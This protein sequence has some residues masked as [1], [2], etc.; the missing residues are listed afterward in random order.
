MPHLI[1]EYSDNI[2]SKIDFDKLLKSAVDT[3]VETGV[4]PLGGIRARA[5][6]MKH[7]HISTG[8][9]KFGYIHFTLKIGAG[10][11][12]EEKKTACDKIWQTITDELK[13]LYDNNIVAISLEV[14]ELHPTLN[15]KKN[16]IHEYLKNN[17]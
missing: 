8:D 12:D 9:E 16:K 1:A 15:Y 17:D 11:S 4:F 3:M 13:S 10:R 6:P 14:V 7:F 5:Y 2:E